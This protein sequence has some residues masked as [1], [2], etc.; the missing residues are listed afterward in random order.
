MSDIRIGRVSGIENIMPS[1]NYSL[2]ESVQ[3]H[4]VSVI[5]SS[6]GGH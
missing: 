3:E 1:R 2:R 4:F 5:T 6:K